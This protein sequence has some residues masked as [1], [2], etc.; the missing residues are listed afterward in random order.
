M[1]V[2]G[3]RWTGLTVGCCLAC[4]V[5]SA[6]IHAADVTGRWR[7]EV[8][9]LHWSQHQK[10]TL[11]DAGGDVVDW[12][13]EDVIDDPAGLLQEKAW[14]SAVQSDGKIEGY[15]IRS[16][17][18]SGQALTRLEGS[19][20]EDNRVVFTAV[21]PGRGEGCAAMGVPFHVQYSDMVE[22]FEGTYD[23]NKK[24]V[25]G[26]LITRQDRKY[27]VVQQGDEDRGYDYYSVE[28]TNILRSCTFSIEVQP[29]EFMV[30]FD[31]GP[32]PGK[33]ETIVNALSNILVDGEP[34]RAGFFMVGVGCCEDSKCFC[35]W[36][37]WYKKKGSVRDNPGLVQTVAGNRHVIGVHTQHHPYLPDKSLE[38]ITVEISQCYY[39]IRRALNPGSPDDVDLPKVFR[40]PY[41]EL[42]KDACTAAN[43]L[44]FNKI[45]LGAGKDRMEAVD[46][47][48]PFLP[49]PEDVQEKAKGFIETSGRDEPCV[50]VFHDFTPAAQDVAKIIKYLRRHEVRVLGEDVE[51]GFTLVHFDPDRL[52]RGI[53]SRIRQAVGTI[54]S[55]E[56][57]R[58]T[59][60]LDSTVSA[61]TFNVS[62]QGSDL[63]LVLYRPDGTRVDPARAL[64]DSRVKYGERDT[65]EYYT[66]SQPAAGTWVMVVSSV[67]VPPQGEKYAIT[68]EGDTD[69]SLFAFADKP[70]YRL[71]ERITV[72]AEL[73][74][75]ETRMS[76][77]SVMARVLR[78]DASVDDLT[79]YDDGMHGDDDGG[80]GLYANAYGNTSLRGSYEITVTAAGSLGTRRY[81]RVSNLAV[82]VGS[83]AYGDVDFGAYAVLA[84]RWMACD[85][86]EPA[87]CDTADLD[88]SGA[89][90]ISDLCVLAERWLEIAP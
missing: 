29:K 74:K 77:A 39:E 53:L 22:S 51:E 63:D 33:T 20:S 75:G 4:I 73:A 28:D 40:P 83:I 55:S 32:V 69:L 16:T 6:T 58:H 36:W 35:P 46:I 21:F 82:M 42:S 31:D 60:P 41:F 49:S 56:T 86:M 15:Y 18:C 5:S 25:T 66:V 61:A 54:H 65:Y 62:W 71:E 52:Q 84:T 10:I 19:I 76:G 44:G 68:V 70:Q 45:I 27:T 23:P 38:E 85:C 90:D 48:W 43:A 1:W 47:G 2:S 57:A 12:M 67:S 80:D 88:Q 78:P 24:I 11:Y 79:L 17:F 50:L 14:G 9:T 81:E 13:E 34:V 8:K 89:V 64:V 3:N 7:L 30:T 37:D 72:R 26:T 87:W 59:I